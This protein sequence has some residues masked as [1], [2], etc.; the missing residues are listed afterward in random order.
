MLSPILDGERFLNEIHSQSIVEEPETNIEDDRETC[1]D[2]PSS[3]IENPHRDDI[4][5]NIPITVDDCETQNIDTELKISNINS[6]K[7]SYKNENRHE[8]EYM[9]RNL[10][11]HALSMFDPLATSTS[12]ENAVQLPDQN[13]VSDLSEL[14]SKIVDSMATISYD[15]PNMYPQDNVSN[16]LQDQIYSFST[17]DISNLT[18]DRTNSDYQVSVDNIN[19]S[20]SRTDKVLS[21]LANMPSTSHGYLIPNAI[22]QE[23]NVLAPLPDSVMLDDN[24]I[25]VSVS[26]TS[27]N[28]QHVTGTHVVDP[29]L[30]EG[31]ISA[32]NA[33]LSSL[34]LTN[35]EYE[36]NVLQTNMDITS[37]KNVSANNIV[38]KNDN[39]NAQKQ[40]RAEFLVDYDS[41]SNEQTPSDSGIC[42]ENTSLDRS[43]D[44]E[45][46]ELNT[47]N[48]NNQ[49]VRNNFIKQNCILSNENNDGKNYNNR[50]NITISVDN[51]VDRNSNNIGSLELS[52]SETSINNQKNQAGTSHNMQ[53]P[54][55][56]PQDEEAHKVCS[57]VKNC[58][59]NNDNR[60][61][62][63]STMCS[64]ISQTEVGNSN[65]DGENPSFKIDH[66]EDNNSS[67][68]LSTGNNVS[69]SRSCSNGETN[70]QLST[71]SSQ[72]QPESSN[73]TTVLHQRKLKKATSPK[74]KKKSRSRTG[75]HESRLWTSGRVVLENR[76]FLDRR[77]P[78]RLNLDHFV[79]DG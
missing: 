22:S 34:L 68:R 53:S 64:G 26:N 76:N 31:S 10:S 44:S 9:V 61:S 55:F 52:Y 35:D 50:D 14:V 59:V 43:P 57:S 47:D 25:L 48:C 28:R 71:A 38:N 51:C 54:E 30:Y 69:R 60:L 67:E 36:N 15:D 74:K 13:L 24:S 42:T 6:R 78:V 12:S 70:V 33:N 20:P 66:C 65:I 3:N 79:D 4:V 56:I 1:V 58:D 7:N 45:T 77:S 11:S 16:L 5:L 8:N 37:Q 17:N 21:Q 63:C 62:E 39:K 32:A 27:L 19:Y 2:D 29:N 18:R 73:V 75:G 72:I 23:P 46:K 41:D 49:S 40:S